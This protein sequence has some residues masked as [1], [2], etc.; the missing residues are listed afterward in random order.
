MAVPWLL[1]AEQQSIRRMASM[2]GLRRSASAYYRFLLEG[3]S[4]PG[5][6]P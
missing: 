4:R 6:M 5:E 1:C 3:K 2:G